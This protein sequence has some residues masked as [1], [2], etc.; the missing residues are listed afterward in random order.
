MFKNLLIKHQVQKRCFCKVK[1]I[2]KEDVNIKPIGWDKAKPFDI[3]PG[4]KPLPIVGNSWRFLSN[5]F[6]RNQDKFHM[7]LHE[8]YGDICNLR[9][10]RGSSMLMVY[11]PEIF[12]MMYRNEGVWPI[13]DGFASLNQYR[14]VTRKDIYNGMGLLTMQGADWHNLRSKVNPIFMQ[15]RTVHLY[16]SSMNL[17]AHDFI[18]RMEKLM[19][20]NNEMPANFEHELNKWALESIGIIT[21]DRRLGCLE[22]NPTEE[23]HA[24]IN[25]VVE[26][27]RLLFL[28]DM[29]AFGNISIKYN[30]G[31]WRKFVKYEDYVTDVC[32]KYIN[33][34]FETLDHNK[35]ENEK[36]A[37]EK[38]LKIDKQFAMI[39]TLDMISAGIDTTGKSTGAILYFLAKNQNVQKKLRE[40]LLEALPDAD[41]PLTKEILNEL[42]YLKAVIK[43]AQR[44]APIGTGNLRKTTKNVVLGGYQIPA[45]VN[46]F[47]GNLYLSRSDKYFPKS[48]EFI[49]ERWLRSTT[50]E[51]S[52][53]NVNPFVSLPF[54][55]GARSC[56]GRRLATLQIE[57]VIAKIIRNFQLD[58]H[59]EDMLFETE[60]LYGI[61][62][63]LKLH[64]TRI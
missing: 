40:E 16:I 38:L 10:I 61:K 21:L 3:I 24:L 55:F 63:P 35:P 17:V 13:R 37:F 43:E 26:L 8:T 23:V 19:A 25:S 11:S 53:K 57:I 56:I 59:Q 1:N 29:T 5:D 14:S 41:T 6:K 31:L 20:K 44:L 15:P 18:K 36:S 54:G 50:G 22:E 42:P 12:E 47:M 28:I 39:M 7:E 9:N 60:L 4:P 46:V 62:S 30:L 51:M 2:S 27:L 33:E 34:A 52:Y 48:K 45:G 64:V 58:W 49:P 32:F